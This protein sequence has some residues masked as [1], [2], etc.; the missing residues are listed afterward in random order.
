M[1]QSSPVAFTAF[2]TS[3]VLYQSTVIKFEEVI[4][5]YG[6][7]YD[8]TTGLFTCPVT[9]LYLVSVKL[10]EKSGVGLQFQT[11][12]DGISGSHFSQPYEDY[13]FSLSGSTLAECQE[14]GT[15]YVESVATGQLN[16]LKASNVFSVLLVSKLD[17]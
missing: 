1:E 11:I 2:A 9:G 16:E 12:V 6:D 7:Q 8:P 13:E 4:F 10:E 15:I 3:Q 5:N 14:G 17:T